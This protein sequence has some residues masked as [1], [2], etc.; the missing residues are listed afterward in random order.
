MQ[1]CLAELRSLEEHA[2]SS[3]MS[4]QELFQFIGA[5]DKKYKGNIE[6]ELNINGI[7]CN[8]ASSLRH[9]KALT[10][11]ARRLNSAV[12]SDES[13]KYLYDLG[14]TI[15]CIA[16]IEMP[17]PHSITDLLS[18]SRFNEARSWFE[19]IN[20]THEYYP[21]AITNTANILEKYGRNLEAIYL[22]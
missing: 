8:V 17:Y 16:E 6:Y 4:E 11:A 2:I 12:A 5:L 20:E 14:N 15:L 22:Y 7:I 10:Y 21:C 1:S 13:D 3:K 9:L 19:R 18:S